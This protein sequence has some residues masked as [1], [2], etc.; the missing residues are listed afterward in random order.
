[1]T[2]EP[3]ASREVRRAEDRA[4]DFDYGVGDDLRRAQQQLRAEIASRIREAARHDP[5]ATPGER[6]V[7]EHAAVIAEQTH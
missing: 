4:R 7:Y 6:R 2:S 5:S 3:T 1:M